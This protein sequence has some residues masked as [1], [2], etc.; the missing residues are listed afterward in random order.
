MKFDRICGILLALHAVPLSTTAQ[1]EGTAWSVSLDTVAV[2]GQRYT[3]PIKQRADGSIIWD[4]QKLDDMPKILG[5]ADPLHF[6]QM[7]PGVQTNNEFRS[8]VN[9]QGCDHSH[10]Q[11]SISGVPIYNVS[12]L[13]GFFS[14]FNGSHYPSMTINKNPMS[15]A[16]PNRLGGE[17]VMELPDQVPDSIN[18][19]MSLGFISSQG[20]LRAPLSKK[21]LLIASLRS[22]YI[23]ML[24]SRWLR[25]DEQDVRYSFYDINAT[26]LYN[27]NSSNS[28]VFDFYH[29][30]DRVAFNNQRDD[31]SMKDS[32]GNIMSAVHWLFKGRQGIKSKSTLFVTSYHNDLHISIRDIMLNIPSDII[33]V[34]A[35]SSM[36][37][38]AFKFGLETIWHHITPL[39]V[40]SESEKSFINYE[41]TPSVDSFEGSMYIN[42]TRSIV[43]NLTINGGL[44]ATL[45]YLKNSTRG[46]VDPTLSL[47]Y[48]NNS[49]QLTACYAIR[50]QYL[51]QTSITNM[52]LPTDFWHSNNA[53]H[54]P[55]YAHELNINAS[56]FLWGHRYKVSAGFFYKKLYHQIE[57]NGSVLDFYNTGSNVYKH[58]IHGKG[59]NYG[60]SVMLNKCSGKLVGW[61]SYTYTQ[62]K[63]RFEEIAKGTYPAF[64]ERPH[65]INAVATCQ[66]GQHWSVGAV[67]VYASGTPFTAPAY[68]GLLNQNIMIAY[69]SHNGNKL[70]PYSRLDFSVNYRWKGRI[71]KENGIN[72]SLYNVMNRS[73]ELFYYV[74]IKENGTFVYKPA[75]LLLKILP[76]LS[77]FCKF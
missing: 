3:S 23:N 43:K 44:K 31:A 70:K 32:W 49:T 4:M 67:F 75:K 59:E 10:T 63:R 2:L 26:M 64:H 41:P 60:Y 28:M 5:N 22:S 45:Y 40:K 55:Q 34:G 30:N 17:L 35:R 48:D 73:N 62:A 15:A 1:E 68:V 6:T 12:H 8:G 19:E 77:F 20:T 21:L 61:L 39:H 65:E 50:H 76:S 51:F 25:A 46:S 11:I 14:V 58:L 56:R 36:T 38:N 69:G 24:Y 71:F 7:L 9:I 52:G 54:Q 72:L 47:M 16:A 13:L 66:L 33:D 53:I 57:Y 42:Y 18:G 37:W 29:G 27:I 74:S